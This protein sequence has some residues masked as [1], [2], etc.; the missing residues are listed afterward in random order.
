MASDPPDSAINPL[1]G[2]IETTDSVW[3]VD[4]FQVRHVIQPRGE[5]A[6]QA[7]FVSVDPRHDHGPRLAISEQG[8]TWVVWWR[9]GET[10]EVLARRRSFSDGGWLDEMVV[11]DK[12]ESS[13]NPEIVQDE[14]ALWIA[15]ELDEEEGTG[16]AVRAIFDDP[17]PLPNRLILTTVDFAGDLDTLIHH[18][19]GHLWVTW[20]DSLAFIGWSEY[21]EETESWGV[22]GYESYASDG[23]DAAR[24][25]IRDAIVGE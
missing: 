12:T 23:V 10:D 7:G 21:D 17:N 2:D 1:S 3:I 19:A 14:Y 6:R 22:L 18:D 24:G 9:E 15:Y 25:R 8:D 11:S 20:V 4:N 13:R 5:N 16:V